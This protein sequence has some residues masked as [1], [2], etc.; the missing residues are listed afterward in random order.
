ML[1]QEARL[2]Q[3]L[4]NKL[5]LAR[6]ASIN[7]TE[8]YFLDS[9][10]DLVG[11]VS[12][13]NEASAIALLREEL[14]RG[15]A[16]ASSCAATWFPKASI[17]I[18]LSPADNKQQQDLYFKLQG[19]QN[20]AQQL[21]RECNITSTFWNMQSSDAQAVKVVRWATSQQAVHAAISDFRPFRLRIFGLAM[22]LQQHEGLAR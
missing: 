1:E 22:G 12:W 8:T 19:L 2:H 5:R 17:P 10:H 4:Q 18:L 6:A 7:D 21:A 15:N 9:C 3:W 13:R 20:Y 14:L 11:V 16:L